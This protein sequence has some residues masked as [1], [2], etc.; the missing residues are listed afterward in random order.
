MADTIYAL[1]SAPG[2]AGVA[3]VRL[4]G[5]HAFSVLSALSGNVRFY[6]RRLERVALKRSDSADLIDEALA[7]YF[8]APHSFTGEDVVEFHL[9][10][11]RA[12]L[13]ALTQAFADY[14]EVRPAAAGEFTRRAFLNDKMD[15]TQAEALADLIDAQTEAQRRQALRQM[16]GALGRLYET[17]RSQLLEIL[18]H[19][20][21]VIDFAED[22]IPHDLAEQNLRAVGQL[23]KE[24]GDH[25][26]DHR[27]G[28]IV[29]DGVSIVLLG[30]P[31][32][33]KSSLMNALARRD[34]AIVSA[35]AGT[36]RDI[37]EV[38][39][40]L[41]GYAVTIADTAGLREVSGEVEREGIR[42]ARARAEAAD[43]RL[44]VFDGAHWPDY[45]AP[46]AQMISPSCL[47]V[48]NKLDALSHPPPQRL[49]DHPVFALSVHTG[50]GM[51]ELEQALL[52]HVTQLIGPTETP[53]LSRERHRHA[54]AACLEHLER[55]LVAPFVDQ[56]AEDV[57][58]A[59]RALG[60]ITGRMDV[61]EIL[62]TIFSQFCIGK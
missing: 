42:R 8:P 30:P 9:H 20:E 50:E 31:N 51:E 41:N 47:I 26:S 61:E 59:A 18:A 13:Q 44:L 35:E 58:L 53:C 38:S 11:G 33:G 10:G 6:P 36:T 60:T 23:I 54:L 25:M 49:H 24:L 48:L 32:A 21:A 15:L 37:I 28:E 5:D 14:P 56:Q 19:N 17:W 12:V 39:L 46:T 45:D 52:T 22:G 3:V 4:S 55:S 40:D 27:R 2:K 16:D 43:L 34:A 29:R 7:V 57:R 1:A 62:E